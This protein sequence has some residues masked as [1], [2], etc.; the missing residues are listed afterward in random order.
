MA[1]PAPIDP[2]LASAVVSASDADRTVADLL[3]QSRDQFLRCVSHEL[4]T[5]V[6]I[7]LIWSNLLR[8]KR[9]PPE[10]VDQALAAIEQS[11]RD[12]K[13][14]VDLLG[15]ASRVSTGRL[16]LDRVP[17]DIASLVTDSLELIAS[18]ADA[19]G[20]RVD[21][22]IVECGS[23]RLDS[24]RFQQAMSHLLS[25]ALR[26]TS[27]GGGIA[28]TTRRH[29]D[30][31]SIEI[32]DSGEGIDPALLPHLFAPTL[33]AKRAELHAD[34][35]APAG[36]GLGLMIAQRLIELHGGRLTVTSA[37]RGHGATFTMQLPTD[38]LDQ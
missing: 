11:A 22:T 6:S 14:L 32:A 3:I 15:D 9:V 2:T 36:L 28:I 34:G 26:H 16:T 10:Q 4:R 7:A 35:G 8:E 18:A 25:N 13:R 33:H 24:D 20:V 31:A 17:N 5:P 37:G 38:S 27:R 23:A 19:K 12:Q 1:E 21:A 29:G 30:E